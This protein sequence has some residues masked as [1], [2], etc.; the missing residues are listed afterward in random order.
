MNGE[1]EEVK[2]A[3]TWVSEIK[4]I[5]PYCNK[6]QE[7]VYEPGDSDTCIHCEKEFKLGDFC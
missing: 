3:I 2:T 4:C 6:E 5:C 7:T 1:N